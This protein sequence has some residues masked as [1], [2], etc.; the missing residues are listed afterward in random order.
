M[1][2]ARLIA[3]AGL[4]VL[5]GCGGGGG[6]PS[7]V[8]TGAQVFAEE[9]CATCHTLARAG[10]SGT[11]GPSLDARPLSAAEVARWVR[12]GGDGMP[13]YAGRL[14]EAEIGAVARYVSG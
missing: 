6:E 2:A 10:S 7:G 9:D 12:D 11:A 1:A 8:R 13:A 5:A 4:A 14:S 3:L